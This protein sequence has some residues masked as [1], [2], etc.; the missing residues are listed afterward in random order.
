M[1][2]GCGYGCSGI[3]GYVDVWMGSGGMAC[4]MAYGNMAI[5]QYGNNMAIEYAM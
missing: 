1:F 2:V 4:G 3:C 5:W